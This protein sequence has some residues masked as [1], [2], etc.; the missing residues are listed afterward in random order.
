MLCIVLV[1]LL[2]G[3][4]IYTLAGGLKATF[5]SSYLH[6]VII[7]IA[8]CIF[9][10][11]VYANTDPSLGIGSPGM[12]VQSNSCCGVV[13]LL[14]CCVVVLLCCCVVVVVGCGL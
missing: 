1:V 4:L 7:M 12:I 8:L 11:L 13:V 14:C 3:V 10:F 9:M 2:I 5:I 6:T